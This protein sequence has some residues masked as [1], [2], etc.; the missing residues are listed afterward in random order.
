MTYPEHNALAE[1]LE[2]I[3]RREQ[4]LQVAAT[5]RLAAAQLRDDR[6]VE[7]RLTQ[8]LAQIPV[9]QLISVAAL[10]LEQRAAEG[11]TRAR[12]AAAHLQG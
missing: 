9:E 5:L 11:D 6:T 4:R 1:A 8:L 10:L 12:D 2:R 7:E 3:A